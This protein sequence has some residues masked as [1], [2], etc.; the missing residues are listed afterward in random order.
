MSQ[1]KTDMQAIYDKSQVTPAML[2]SLRNDYQ[3]IN[4]AATGAATPIAIGAL[5]AD[6]AA[7]GDSL[8][9][10]AQMAQIKADVQALVASRGVTDPTLAD[11]AFADAQTVLNASNFTAADMTTIAADTKAISDALQAEV[12]ALATASSTGSSTASTTAPA[13]PRA[14]ESLLTGLFGPLL[15]LTTPDA[16]TSNPGPVFGDPT[17]N[18]PALASLGVSGTSSSLT[19]SNSSDTST[20]SS[21]SY[22]PTLV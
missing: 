13:L 11:K 3:A 9:N 20:G 4:K 10:D 14:M 17:S 15:G 21:G 6:F 5:K 2:A 8:P 19:Q 7:V 18:V 12:I 22:S 1:L 16:I